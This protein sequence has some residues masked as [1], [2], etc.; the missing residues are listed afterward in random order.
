MSLYWLKPAK[1]RLLAPVVRPL[2]SAGVTPNIL[3]AAGL[4][5]SAAAGLVAA[6][7]ALSPAVAVFLLGA[8]FDALDGSLAR[9]AGRTS[10]YGL[11]LDSVCDRLA[12]TVFVAGAV[13]GGVIAGALSPRGWRSGSVSG[14]LSWVFGVSVLVLYT[15]YT[16]AR[17]PPASAVGGHFELD[18]ALAALAI[19]AFIILPASIL[20][21]ALG[22]TLGQLARRRR[23]RGNL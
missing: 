11:Y 5:V 7:G 1:D 8:C 13:A 14:I 18:F 21:G 15:L 9:T 19:M 17:V 6:S 22:G 3:S 23:A 4:L 20:G 16:F 12:E 10:E 2:S